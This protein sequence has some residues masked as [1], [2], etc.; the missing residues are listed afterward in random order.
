[1]SN[2]NGL[3]AQLENKVNKEYTDY[4]NSLYDLDAGE[5]IKSSYK[6][7]MLRSFKNIL[8]YDSGEY[9]NGIL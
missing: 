5:I 7:I 9:W 6:T 2:K 4:I 3:L 1:M 8:S